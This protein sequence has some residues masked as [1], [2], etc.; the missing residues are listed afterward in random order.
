MNKVK[1][2]VEISENAYCLLE[3]ES[4][5][6]GSKVDDILSEIIQEYLG[7]GEWDREE[8]E[9]ELDVDSND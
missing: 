3:H 5:K 2:C 1:Y 9:R 6:H 7:N 4:N 8:Y